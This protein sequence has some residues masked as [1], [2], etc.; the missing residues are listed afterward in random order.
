LL[1]LQIHTVSSSKAISIKRYPPLRVCIYGI[2]TVLKRRKPY[3]T[4]LP[5]ADISLNELKILV[6]VCFSLTVNFISNRG[7]DFFFIEHDFRG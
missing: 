2:K 7:F 4:L 6:A 1:K 5:F 3:A